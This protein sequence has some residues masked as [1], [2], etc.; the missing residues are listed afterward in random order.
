MLETLQTLLAIYRRAEVFGY[1]KTLM[2]QATPDADDRACAYLEFLGAVTC[3]VKLG[4]CTERLNLAQ[5]TAYER[6]VKDEKVGQELASL[7]VEASDETDPAR[8]IGLL[9]CRKPL[10]ETLNR[11]VDIIG[12]F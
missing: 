7:L 10:T 1:T 8:R 5:L 11:Y 12:P 4:G 2:F 3:L 9:L 6:F